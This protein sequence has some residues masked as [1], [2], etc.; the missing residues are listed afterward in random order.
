MC[1]Q[2]FVLVLPVSSQYPV[3]GCS[4][5]D[6]NKYRGNFKW[7]KMALEGVLV[8]SRRFWEAPVDCVCWEGHSGNAHSVLYYVL[9][10]SSPVPLR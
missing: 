4:G 8:G 10:M 5:G 1:S 3:S 9:A 7:E 6:E 2:V